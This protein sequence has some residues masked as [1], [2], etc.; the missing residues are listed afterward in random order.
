MNEIENNVITV[1]LNDYKDKI[2]LDFALNIIDYQ[3]L[4][5]NDKI[6]AVKTVLGLNE[7]ASMHDIIEAVEELF[8]YTSQVCN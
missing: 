1:D 4:D 5:G 2:T 3:Y 6:K 7:V 8:K